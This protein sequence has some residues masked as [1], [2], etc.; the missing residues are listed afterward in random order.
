ME[1]GTCQTPDP[2]SRKPPS[3]RSIGTPGLLPRVMEIGV[4]LPEVAANRLAGPALPCRLRI[5]EES[6]Q[7]ST[8]GPLCRQTV[9]SVVL[10]DRS[11]WFAG[12]VKS[13]AVVSHIVSVGKG[14]FFPVRFVRSL[15]HRIQPIRSRVDES[16]QA[17]GFPS[18]QHDCQAAELVP[19]R[20]EPLRAPVRPTKQ[21]TEDKRL[22]RP[23]ACSPCCRPQVLPDEAAPISQSSHVPFMR[24]DCLHIGKQAIVVRNNSGNPE[25]NKASCAGSRPGSDA[26]SQA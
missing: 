23:G 10:P 1:G 2:V 20:S 26:P 24:C 21:T 15:Q 22:M 3:P 8:P 11:G 17:P 18:K 13:R 25:R 9:S 19:C 7:Y 12:G 5:R 6:E 14:G 16:R 4:L